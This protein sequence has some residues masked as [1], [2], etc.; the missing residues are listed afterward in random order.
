[1]KRAASVLLDEEYLRHFYLRI[2]EYQLKAGHGNI[3]ERLE[4]VQRNQCKSFKWYLDNVF[5]EKYI[6]N[7]ADGRYG[8]LKNQKTGLCIDGYGNSDEVILYACNVQSVEPQFFEYSVNKELRHN[9]VDEECLTYILHPDGRKTAG[10]KPCT[11]T[12]KVPWNQK[13]IIT[14]DN[15]IQI[16]NPRE[17]SHLCMSA[18]ENGGG[19][20]KLIFDRCDE[21]KEEQKWH[22][23]AYYKP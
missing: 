18:V 9:Y 3:N 5:P 11:D 7:D 22:F 20:F 2:P 19:G 4:L 8:A 10:I 1:V 14:K 23:H 13:W 6:P 15:Q 21:E 17:Q 16:Q 12:N